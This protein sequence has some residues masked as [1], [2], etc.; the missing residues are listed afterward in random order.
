META[1]KC[2]KCGRVLKSPLSIAMGMGPVFDVNFN[3]YSCL[4]GLVFDVKVGSFSLAKNRGPNA[5]VY[6][7]QPERN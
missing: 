5:L 4:S 3:L 6:H 1:V 2:K 7:S